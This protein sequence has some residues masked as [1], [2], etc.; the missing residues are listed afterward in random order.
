MISGRRSWKLG[1]N[2]SSYARGPLLGAAEV[3]Y[4]RGW[5]SGPDASS[6]TSEDR[7][8]GERWL[9]AVANATIMIAFS[10]PMRSSATTGEAPT[11]VQL[12]SST[13]M[14]IADGKGI[15]L[16]SAWPT[17]GLRTETAEAIGLGAKRYEYDTWV[18]TFNFARGIAVGAAGNGL[19]AKLKLEAKDQVGLA[20]DPDPTTVAH[21]SSHLGRPWFS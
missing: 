11:V 9:N 8:P 2:G 5:S 21:H 20:L 7:A 10:K 6:R 14:L 13:G 18:A 1:G 4:Y 15:A 3:I 12:V 17:T 16:A 19:D